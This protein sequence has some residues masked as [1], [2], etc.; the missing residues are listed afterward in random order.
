MLVKVCSATEKNIVKFSVEE[1]RKMKFSEKLTKLRKENNKSQEQLADKLGVSRQAVSKWESGISVPDMEKMM[2]LCKILNCNLEDLVDDGVASNSKA[3]QNT[4]V[5]FN[6]NVYYKEV[7]DFITKTLNMFWS[8]QLIDKIKCLL[9]MFFLGIVIYIGWNIIGE[10]IHSC[11]SSILYLMPDRFSWY[12]SSIFGT[13]YNI[14]GIV[15]GIV[16]IIHIFKI[17]YLDYFVTI[18]DSEV[19]NKTIETPVEEQEKKH[20][21]QRQFIEKKKNKIIIRDAKH[22]TYG[23]FDFLAK[24]TIYFIKFLFILFAIPCVICFALMVFSA[25]VSIWYMKDG[26][27]FSGVFITIMGILVV[28]YAVLKGIYDFV[29]DL[30][31]SFRKIFVI[32]IV[33][34]ILFGIGGSVAFCTYLSF[35]KI[36]ISSNDY[37]TSHHEFEYNDKMILHFLKDDNVKIVIDDSVSNIKIDINHYDQINSYI[38]DSRYYAPGDCC[39]DEDGC[40]DDE[41]TCEIDNKDYYSVYYYDFDYINTEDGFDTVNYIVDMIKDKKRFIDYLDYQ[42]CDITIT[43]SRDILN[44]LENNYKVMFD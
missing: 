1:V 33:G 40:A 43:T 26:I 31:Q 32:S 8:M 10:I 29:F 6:W 23:F 37:T 27:F 7:L 12:L 2:Q 42:D 38:Y 41:I 19:K 9:E 25:G 28:N 5:K 34:L 39:D 21:E 4:E 20:P 44:K 17:R 35:D 36:N 30:K 13:I 16:L 15:I 11:F 24:M 3:N 18:E 22:S 14:F